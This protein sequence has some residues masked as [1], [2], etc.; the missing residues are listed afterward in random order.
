M[1]S[2]LDHLY[3]NLLGHFVSGRAGFATNLL[4][5][6]GGCSASYVGYARSVP[7]AGTANGG[8]LAF[9]NEPFLPSYISIDITCR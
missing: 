1:K 6:V 7:R 5:V 3:F 8:N 4:P 2:R 9:W